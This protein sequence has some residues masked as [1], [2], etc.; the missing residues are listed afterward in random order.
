MV[1]YVV[2]G[3]VIISS[4]LSVPEVAQFLQKYMSKA[5]GASSYFDRFVFIGNHN[6]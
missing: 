1:A 4:L 3:W 6:D 2:L 5:L